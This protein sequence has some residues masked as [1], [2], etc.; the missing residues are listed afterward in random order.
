MGDRRSRRRAHRCSWAG[1]RRTCSPGSEAPAAGPQARPGAHRR[2]RGEELCGPRPHRGPS[3]RCRAGW[4]C[5]CRG[6]PASARGCACACSCTAWPAALPPLC[7]CS[8]AWWNG[9]ASQGA[10]T[11]AAPPALSSNATRSGGLAC[12]AGA[13]RSRSSTWPRRPQPVYCRGCAR[14]HRR[15]RHVGRSIEPVCSIECGSPV[16]HGLLGFRPR[17]SVY[18]RECARDALTGRS[19]PFALHVSF[20]AAPPVI[21]HT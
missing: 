2:P 14:H 1:V 13:P 9:T 7:A 16:R 10:V 12:A 21:S 19:G 17:Q 6:C 4:P 3:A 15:R 8:S 18:C 20:A 5:T 11:A